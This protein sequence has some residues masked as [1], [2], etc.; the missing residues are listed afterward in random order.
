MREDVVPVRRR[1]GRVERHDGGAEP[2][3]CQKERRDLEPVGREDG[4]AIAAPHAE[5]VPQPA[6][7][8]IDSA[9]QLAVGPLA[10]ARLAFVERERRPLRR[11]ARETVQQRGDVLEARRHRLIIIV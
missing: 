3:G 4:D 1:G 9:E 5:L 6:R 7:E 11:E 2:H 10:G 8:S